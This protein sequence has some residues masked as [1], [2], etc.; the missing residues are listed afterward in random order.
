[1]TSEL[2]SW[3]RLSIDTPAWY[4][5]WVDGRV[6]DELM[7]RLGGLDR[8]QGVTEQTTQLNGTLADQAALLGVLRTLVHAG[9]ALLSIECLGPLDEPGACVDDAPRS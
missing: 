1:M 4:V 7:M 9:Y 6:S 3:A 2:S 8:D 5:F